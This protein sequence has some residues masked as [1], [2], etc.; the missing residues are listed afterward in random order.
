[1]R[2]FSE[3]AEQGFCTCPGVLALI[4]TCGPARDHAACQRGVTIRARI[5]ASIRSIP[6]T[7]LDRAFLKGSKD[8]T[9][10][11]H[12]DIRGGGFGPFERTRRL[13]HPTHDRPLATGAIRGLTGI[14]STLEERRRS[15]AFNVLS[16]EEH[17]GLLVDRE[18]ADRD[19]KKLAS[20][21]KFAALRQDA[22]ARLSV[23]EI[24]TCAHRVGFIAA[25]WRILQ[26]EAGPQDETLLI[27]CL[28]GDTPHRREGLNR[29][30]LDRIRSCPSGLNR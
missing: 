10:L 24:W 9:P 14:A 27:R 2:A 7:G 26:M 18:A 15:P 17:L 19:G 25:S 1:M 30:P 20:L 22:S 5:V 12:A 23:L 16:C 28:T 3:M 13:T 29:R 4:K 6:K 21:L 8:V 11:Q